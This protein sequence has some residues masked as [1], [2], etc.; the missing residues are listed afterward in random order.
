MSSPLSTLRKISRAPIPGTE[1][2]RRLYT[3]ASDPGSEAALFRKYFPQNQSGSKATQRRSPKE[4]SVPTD[5]ELMSSMMQKISQL[6]K[7]VKTQEQEINQKNKRI[8]V[9]EEKL[10]L[11]LDVE[12]TGGQKQDEDRMIKRCQKL[13]KQVWEME[14]FLNDY[15]MIWV[16]SGDDDDGDDDDDEDETADKTHREHTSSKTSW[17]AEASVVRRFSVNFDLVLKNIQELNLMAGG[18]SITFVPGGAKLAERPSVPLWLFTNGIAMFNGPFRSYDHPSTQR[19]MQDIMDGYFPSELQDRFP[20]GVTFQVHDRRD[21][22]FRTEFPGKGHMTGQS[23]QKETTNTVTG[24][25]HYRLP[26]RTLSVQQFVNKLP[27][28]VVRAGNVISIRSALR[29]HLQGL[30]GAEN[31][32]ENIIETPALRTLRERSDSGTLCES[33]VTS[34]R[35]KSEDRETTFLLKMFFNETVGH[36]RQYL[37]TH[38]GSSKPPYDIISALPHP[39]CH[40]ND[41]QTLQACGLTPNAALILRP[42]PPSTTQRCSRTAT[43]YTE[44]RFVYS[45]TAHMIRALDV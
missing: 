5:M 24:Q 41:S 34:L 29:T 18:T 7:K 12:K 27:E 9:L 3:D 26:G 2:D 22:E 37:D 30:E 15:G 32:Q 35:V 19:C 14:R 31:H 25:S 4:V 44:S 38:R 6:E 16:G 40:N 17:K 8:S 45:N 42:R 13:Q 43:Q 1:G 21:E 39:H 28:R 11:R 36:L 33:D 20:D 23:E 10:K